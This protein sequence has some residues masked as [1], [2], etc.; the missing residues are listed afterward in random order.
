MI[1]NGKYQFCGGYGWE[2]TAIDVNVTMAHALQNCYK[3]IIDILFDWSTAYLG[4]NAKY[5]DKCQTSASVLIK[6]KTW[7]PQVYRQDI[8]T[9]GTVVPTSVQYCKALPLIGSSSASGDTP[10]QMFVKRAY[11]VVGNYFYNTNKDKSTK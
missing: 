6:V 11:D 4:E 3:T 7:N 10:T 8:V 5:I 2:S 9:G 1:I